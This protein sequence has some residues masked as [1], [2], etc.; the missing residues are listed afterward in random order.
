[1]GWV[2]MGERDLQ[3]IGVL[4][5]V[6]AG[7]RNVASAATVLDLSVRQVSRLMLWYR[8]GGGG[9]LH[10]ARGRTPN[11]HL[12]SGVGEYALELVRRNYRD[13]GPT[14]AT[15]ALQDRHGIKVGRETVR[16]W[17]VAD[18]L[19]LSRKQSKI[20]TSH[21]SVE[22]PNVHQNRDSVLAVQTQSVA[23]HSRS[24]D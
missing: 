10:Q 1:L 11:N 9:A 4:T 3:R 21:G 17:M 19:W 15:E 8:D 16:K 20:S 2:M 24:K 18:G 13:I 5:E 7:P 22:S 12:E 14:L 23:A 6:L